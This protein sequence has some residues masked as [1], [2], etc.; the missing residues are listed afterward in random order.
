[1]PDVEVEITKRFLT[2]MADHV[3]LGRKWVYKK[4][5]AERM[6]MTHQE[7]NNLSNGRYVQFRHLIRINKITGVNY[8]WLLTGKGPKYASKKVYSQLNGR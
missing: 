3:G 1:M 5:F 2:V 7:V 6:G 8:E 4:D